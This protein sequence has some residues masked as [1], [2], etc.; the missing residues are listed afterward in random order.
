MILA[1]PAEEEHFSSEILQ[2]NWPGGTDMIHDPI[3]HLRSEASTLP[4]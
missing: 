1:V 3:A 4:T 2:S